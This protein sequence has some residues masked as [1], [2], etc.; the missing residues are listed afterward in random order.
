M[1]NYSLQVLANAWEIMT[2]FGDEPESTAPSLPGLV[3]EFHSHCMNLTQTDILFSLL[4]EMN[5]SRV[6]NAALAAKSLRIL[7]QASPEAKSRSNRLGA[8]ERAKQCREIGSALH[9]RLER[10]SQYLMETL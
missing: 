5:G 4:R 1:T 2:T 9:A 3:D 8:L 10:E 7:C 6:H